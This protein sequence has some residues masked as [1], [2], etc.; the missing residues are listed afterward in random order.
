MAGDEQRKK[1]A[2]SSS[3]WHFLY[4]LATESRNAKDPLTMDSKKQKSFPCSKQVLCIIQVIIS[5]IALTS[6]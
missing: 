6:F 1:C 4:T 2:P 5:F 3:H